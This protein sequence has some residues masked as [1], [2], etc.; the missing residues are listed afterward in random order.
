MM[1]QKKKNKFFTFIFSLLPGAAEMYMGFMKNGLSMMIIFFITFLPMAAFNSME[2]MMLLSAVV[3]F[4]GFFHARNI[5]GLDDCDFND[6][7]DIY[8]W[9]E[10]GDFKWKDYDNKKIAKWI[11]ILFIFIGVAQLWDYLFYEI[12]CRLIPGDYW[13]D[14]YPVI[15]DIPQV[16]F[17]ILFIIIG[18]NMI[19]GK[20]KELDSKLEEEIT[21]VEE[22]KPE[23][24]IK[25]AEEI[26]QIED[27]SK[28]PEEV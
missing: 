8:I 5:A 13:N 21:P 15:K 2:F 28:D 23:E 3:W 18:I 17:A 6:L 1:K 22:I 25:P 10:F 26:A 7:N 14:I 12:I 27:K 20:K 19:R 24:E 9:E 4:Y 16:I 11:A